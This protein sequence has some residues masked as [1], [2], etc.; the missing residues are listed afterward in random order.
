L[1]FVDY[2]S[3]GVRHLGSIYEGL[4]EYQPCYAA[5]P[6]VVVRENSGERWVVEAEAPADA[7][8]IERRD[9][10][11]VYLVTDRG[12]RKAT[13]SYYTPQY[14]VE[15]IVE[16]TVGPLVADAKA[17]V[18][19]A[20]AEADADVDVDSGALLVEALL[21]LKVLDPAMGSGHFLVEA[22][23]FLARALTRDHYVTRAESDEDDVTYWKRRV[24]ERCIYGVDKN[25]LAVEL[26][27]LSLWLATVA[28]DRPLSFLNHHLKWG[29][30]LVGAQ[31]ADLGDVPTMMLSK[32]ARKRRAQLRAA[33]ARQANLFE[34]RLTEKLPVMMGKV[35]EIVG[36]E[37]ADYETVR[38]KEAADAAVRNLKAPF[39]AVAHLW[40][41]AYFGNA[42]DAGTYREALD[43]ISQ[44]KQLLAMEAV[45]QAQ[46]MADA[47]GFFH[48]ELAFPEVFY[49]AEGQPLGE[50]A[51]FDA[52]VGNPPYSSV[53]GKQFRQYFQKA[54]ESPEYQYDTFV[55][56]IENGVRLSRHGGYTSMIV[57]TTFM[58]E[59]YGMVHSPVE[60]G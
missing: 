1:E 49:D 33:G 36:Q 17:R 11:K 32:K 5:E 39:E 56:F 54:F 44:P 52:V 14:I 21:D 37:S 55:L 27:K 38:A 60:L 24:V 43:A 47:R 29:D 53:S 28:A 34:T 12:E 35:L 25:P 16:Q 26:A 58:V 51:G 20:A 3:L 4:L 48:W 31:V 22:T 23:E 13:G 40:T 41:S 8:V 18:K 59:H 9:T 46:A 30:S 7:H 50:Q 15:Y 19:A 2:R 42:F 6:M 10:G 45:E 57:P